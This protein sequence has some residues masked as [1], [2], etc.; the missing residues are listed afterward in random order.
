M[1]D[2][3]PARRAPSKAVRLRAVWYRHWKV[4][5]KFIVANATPAVLEPTFFLLAVGFGLGRYI[6]R[7]FNGLE[8]DAYMAPALLAMTS[9]YTAAF[10]ASYGTFIRL[11]YQKA[12]EGMLATP[13]TRHDI[14]TGELLWCGSK[15]LL[16]SSIVALVLL[17]FGHLRT[18]W[19]VLVPAIGFLNSIVFAGISY[20]V[21]S[22]VKN[23]NH[24]QFYF[25]IGL[26]PLG[27]LSGLVFP[28]REL[29]YGLEYAAYATPLF[30]TIETFR[31]V[32]SGPAHTSVAWAWA[33]P[34]VLVTMA[35][36]L[37]A[38]GVRRMKGRL[39]A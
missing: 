37:G 4:Y 8:Y 29:P 10:E 16:F 35:I 28:V 6:H 27:L 26:T 9:M 23:I 38:L 39:K 17:A 7:E 22:W 33:C 36:V 1:S 25:T 3:A 12:Y 24:F 31:L 15:G 11:R 34:L 13:L 5:S 14:F 19:A 2:A 18:P 32:V 21:T 20:L 30:H